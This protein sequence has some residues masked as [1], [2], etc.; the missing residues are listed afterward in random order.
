[1]IKLIFIDIDN[2]LLD[3]DAYVRKA[4]S[5]GFASFGLGEY[6]PHVFDVFTKVNQQLWWRLEE[7]ELTFEQLHDIRFNQIF[8]RLGIDFDGV[9]FENYFRQ[10][11][12]ECAIPVNGAYEMLQ[13]LEGKYILCTASNGPYEQQIHRMRLADM[14]KY[15]DYQFIS[16]KAGISKPARGFFDYAFKEINA[17]RKVTIRPEECLIIGDSETSDMAGGIGYGM[18]TAYYMRQPQ[19]SFKA[20]Y[21]I[22]EQDLR[23]IPN[24]IKGLE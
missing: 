3:F 11:L 22:V 12:R 2:T 15:F 13:E 8:E 17:D 7:G 20:E 19:D 21:D 16:E 6:G 1:M 5:S 4:L 10:Q 9:S 24:L 18:R 23:K 14:S